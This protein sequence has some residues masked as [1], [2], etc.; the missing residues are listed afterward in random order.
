[1]PI[2]L[3]ISRLFAKVTP[4]RVAALLGLAAFIILLGAGLFSI[5]EGVGYGTALYWGITTGTT[6]GYGDVTPHTAAGKIIASFVMLTT[7]PIVG[8]VFALLAGAAAL[9]HIRRILGMDSRLPTQPY[10]AIYGDHPIIKRVL[11]ELHRAGDP[12]VLVAPSRPAGTRDDMEFVGGDPTDEGIVKRSK[13]ENASRA[14]IACNEDA[15]TLVVAVNLH[16]VAP[17]LK[18]Y[19]LTHSPHVARALE[20]LGVTHTLATEDLLG[21]TLAKSLETPEA[22]D[23]LLQLV[24]GSTYKLEEEVASDALASQTLS[25]ARATPGTLVLGIARDG[26]VDLGVGTDPVISAGDRLIVLHPC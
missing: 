20:Q 21:H 24:D 8:A 1:M 9:A 19:A 16:T 7:I 18:V 10:T 4:H 6:V 15:D 26:G 22:G 5:A 13:P 3:T 12:A 23:L 17:H 14:L 11:D 2:F 25:Q